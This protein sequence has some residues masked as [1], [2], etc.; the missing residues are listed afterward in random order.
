MTDEDDPRLVLTLEGTASADLE[1]VRPA[2]RYAAPRVY[3]GARGRSGVLKA[4]EVGAEQ[5]SELLFGEAFEGLLERGAFVFGRCGRDGYVG[6]TARDGL[7]EAGTLPTHQVRALATF[8]F[9]E[10][11][12]KRPVR[13]R[14]PMNA[15]VT[16]TGR[17]GA[18]AELE[19]GGYAPLKHLAP[20]G[21]F[22]ERPHEVAL[23]FLGAPYLWGG[24]TADGLDCSGLVQAA[25]FACGL[26]APRDS[27]QQMALGVALEPGAALEGLQAGDLV[28]WRGHV[29]VL[30][31]AASL[32]H[33]NAW[34]M[35]VA[36]EPLAE[37][38]ARIEGAG[39]GA[40]TAFRRP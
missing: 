6:W 23:R 1:G 15:L 11:S 13:T 25:R 20:L 32:V 26:A 17:E 28:F 9:A 31:S 12:I 29:G 37:A 36:R 38:I 14:L 16:V 7:A 8:A 33:A 2:A 39:G 40:P 27:D 21:V 22:D 18:F 35:C 3:R 34:A 24:R 5:V 30:E 19:D 10:P 4:P